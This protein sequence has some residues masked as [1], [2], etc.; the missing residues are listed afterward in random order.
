MISHQVLLLG[1][2]A[3]CQVLALTQPS[4]GQKH[5]VVFPKKLH[6]Q[7][8]RDTE[9]SKYPDIVQYGLEMEGKPVVLHLEKTEDLISNN[10][11]ETSYSSDGTPVT[12]TPEIQDHC[13]YQGSVKN[14]S[15]S[16]A[17]ISTCRGI[18]GI[19]LTGGRRYLIAPLKQTDSEE[20]AVYPYEALENTPLTC[21]VTNDTYT[22]DTITMVAR[23]SSSA[24]KQAL[25]QSKKYVE[26]YIV[27][28]NSMFI[29][30][31]RNSE[32]LKQRIFEI[33]NF[34]NVVYKGVNTFVALTGI[35]I[36]DRRDE[37][38]V[39]SNPSTDLSE[40]S[41]WRQEKLLP[42][43]SHD[44]AQFL[45]NTDF[46]GSTVG[47]AY[48]STFCSSSHS[49][50]VIQ[51]HSD[52]SIAIGATLAHEMGHNLGM[53]HDETYCSCPHESCVMADTLSYNTPSL[54]SV[55]SHRF[56][57]EFI[58]K[59][60]PMCMKNMPQKVDIKAPPVCGNKFTESGEDC[61][62]GP[63]EECRNP[64]CDATT[65]KLKP[66]AQCAEGEC[67]ANC[68]VK[69][70]GIVCRPAKDDCDLAEMCGGV[71]STCPSDRF[72]INGISCKNG[73]GYCFNGKCPTLNSQCSALWGSGA[74]V[75][76]SCFQCNRGVDI[77]QNTRCASSEDV[78][79]GVLY[80]SGG[81]DTPMITGRWST[82]NFNCKAVINP[83]ITVEDGTHCG[84]GK[85]CQNGR[86]REIE[87]AYSTEQCAT[88]CQEHAVCDSE[89]QC[90]CEAGYAPPDCTST[91]SSSYIIVIVIVLIIVCLFIIGVAYL[92]YKRSQR[93]K[94]RYIQDPT[95]GMENPTF[96]IQER[97][98][99]QHV[100]KA[101]M[102][103][104][105]QSPINNL[106]YPPT[107][108]PQYP[109]VNKP[110]YPPAS[111]SA[112]P[113]ASNPPYPPANKP[114]YPPA[115]KTMFPVAPPQKPANSPPYPPP[116]KPGPPHQA[117]SRCYIRQGKPSIYYS[118]ARVWTA[119]F[120][121]SHA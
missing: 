18:S 8:K 19:I 21:G 40:F 1:C 62:C 105:Y 100:S 102:P 94:Q 87:I 119:W 66:E 43:K 112:F 101:Q 25:L 30:Y 84:D 7:H 63:V 37:F 49:T 106:P 53:L 91:K 11:T 42:R 59:H 85:V 58:M 17:S 65:C 32:T 64:C 67:C 52:R 78:L 81:S 99:G 44:N 57:Q 16:W 38:Q 15:D 27:A 80:C 33:V 114:Q 5:E 41:K 55:C 116:N 12:S 36:W 61:D 10:Y 109:P 104:A 75:R 107:N 23:S 113:P 51:D 77:G 70:A 121:C 28:D 115:N 72:R 46:D 48:I 60:M 92:V 74:Q 118:R 50:G 29:K 79:C 35:E 20:H 120:K 56:Y 6:T 117:K 110:L 34:V 24:E 98:Y 39:V 103:Q 111:N 71:T 45:T 108:K 22:D 86:C 4:S 73:Q 88:K 54:F 83:L 26:L 95:S 97:S 89:L 13:Y 14:E 96:N 82:V 2:L 93:K 31:N 69:E 47:L 90:Q 68:Q 9:Q 76:A 3:C